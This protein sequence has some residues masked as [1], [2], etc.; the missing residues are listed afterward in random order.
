MISKGQVVGEIQNMQG[1]RIDNVISP[2]DGV[3]RKIFAHYAVTAG[4]VVVEAHL[5]PRAVPPFPAIVQYV[6]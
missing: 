6:F 4:R 1:E 3:V 2:E 5:S